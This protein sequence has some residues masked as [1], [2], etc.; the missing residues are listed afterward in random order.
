ML[1]YKGDIKVSDMLNISM[2]S[3]VVN[4][5]QKIIGGYYD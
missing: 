2:I 5:N 1:Q 3:A 4:Q